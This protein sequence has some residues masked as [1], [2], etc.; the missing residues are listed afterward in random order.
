MWKTI[1]H[2]KKETSSKNISDLCAWL[3]KLDIFYLGNQAAEAHI[4]YQY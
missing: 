2:Y 1:S 3:Q 4:S